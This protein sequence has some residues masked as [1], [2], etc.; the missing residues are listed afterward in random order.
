MGPEMSGWLKVKLK[1][2][3]PLSSMVCVRAW[4]RQTE[5]CVV[6]SHKLDSE[7]RWEIGAER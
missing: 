4:P 1:V 6:S 5:E 3:Q 7:H 2:S